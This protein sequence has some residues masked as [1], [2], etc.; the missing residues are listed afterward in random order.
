[1]RRPELIFVPMLMP[2]LIV[3]ALA[4]TPILMG[5]RRS[6][7]ARPMDAIVTRSIPT[8]PLDCQ[9]AGD[10]TGRTTLIHA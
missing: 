1:M 9:V 5:V 4:G 10:T 3:T 6:A 8:P 2:M 7:A